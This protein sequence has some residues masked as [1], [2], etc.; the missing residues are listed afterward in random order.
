LKVF[1]VFASAGL[2]QDLPLPIL[3]LAGRANSTIGLFL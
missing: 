1:V 2:G 3:E